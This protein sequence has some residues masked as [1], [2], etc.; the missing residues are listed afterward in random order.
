[1]HILKTCQI[2][3]KVHQGLC[4]D[5]QAA[6]LIKPS[7]GQVWMATS[8]PCSLHDAKEAIIQGHILCFPDP[9]RRHI[10]YTDALHNSCGAQLS[11][12]HD[13]TKFPIAFL[14]HI[15]TETQRKCSTPEQEAYGVYY[16][17]TKWNYCLQGADIIVCNDHKPLAKFLNGK[18][19]TLNQ[20]MG[21]GTC[22]LRYHIWVNIMK[23]A[24]NCLSIL[25]TLPNG[26][27][28][29]VKMLI[30]TNLDG[31]AFNTRSKTS[32]QHQRTTDTDPSDTPPIKETITLD[33]PTV[34][35]SQDITPK[36][37]IANSCEALLQIHKKDPLL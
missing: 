25:V 34:E 20:Q 11:Q 31:P 23:Q 28:A 4:K 27:K 8:A 15:F 17:I 7:Q 2:L 16:A 24:A 3:W 12:E 37:L 10:V 22:G 36:P 30:A 9:A 5:G 33:L 35:T 32:Q 18:M 19:P 13:R 26:N 21:T 1:M 29:T 6:N 14:S